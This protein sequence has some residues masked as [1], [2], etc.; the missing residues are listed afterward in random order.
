MHSFLSS[1]PPRLRFDG[2]YAE[3]SLP[4]AAVAIRLLV[5]AATCAPSLAGAAVIAEFDPVRHN[6][7]LT[8]FESNPAFF[9]DEG[10]ISGVALNRAT[11]VTPYLNQ[12]SEITAAAGFELQIVTVTSVPEPATPMILIAI[13]CLAWRRISR[14]SR[15]NMCCGLTAFAP[16]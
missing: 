14:R 15:G 1:C 2:R 16:N 7:F 6:R 10:L 3:C 12:I 13:G 9:I 11:L 8:G 4:I 5:V